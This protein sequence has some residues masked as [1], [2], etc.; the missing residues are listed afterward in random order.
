MLLT[1]CC[2]TRHELQQQTRQSGA[3]GVAVSFMGLTLY[4]TTIAVVGPEEM[5]VSKTGI[6]C[7]QKDISVDMPVDIIITSRD[8]WGA[9]HPCGPESDW[10]ISAEE[11]SARMLSME[12]VACCTITAQFLPLKPGRLTIELLYK[13]SII[14]KLFINIKP[15]Q[16]YDPKYTKL[17]L[18]NDTGQDIT[19]HT[20]LMGKAKAI[21]TVSPLDVTLLVIST[22]SVNGMAAAGPSSDDIVI[23]GAVVGEVTE[24]T[25]GLYKC[26]LSDFQYGTTDIEVDI[27]GITLLCP[28]TVITPGTNADPTRTTVRCNPPAVLRGDT[29]SVIISFYDA[30]GK[31]APAPDT[32]QLVLEPIG[33]I[34]SLTRVGSISRSTLEVVFVCEGLGLVGLVVNHSGCSYECTA[35]VCDI[36]NM[37]SGPL[38]L[39]S[40][41]VSLAPDPV[42]PGN[43]VQC[44]ITVRDFRYAPLHDVD[45]PLNIVLRPLENTARV[46]TRVQAVP[47]TAS[48]W[49]ATFTAGREAGETGVAVEVNGHVFY[50]TAM[51]EEELFD[52]LD[53]ELQRLREL[54]N[55]LHDDTERDR[56]R[57]GSVAR[58][59]R[60]YE[61][62]ERVAEEQ[63][64]E[65]ELT[66]KRYFS[67]NQQK[68]EARNVFPHFGLEVTDSIKFRGGLGARF[69]YAGVKVVAVKGASLSS[70]VQADD[71]ITK[72]EGKQ[73]EFLSDFRELVQDVQPGQSVEL[74]VRS[75][76][77][78]V[79]RNITIVPER[80]SVPSAQRLGYTRRIR[81]NPVDVGLPVSPPRL[82]RVARDDSTIRSNS[83][84]RSRR[85]VLIATYVTN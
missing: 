70:G 39:D 85:F 40:T 62:P 21:Q 16:I 45:Q 69:E 27:D 1:T 41:D 25:T 60:S 77:D 26:L 4:A 9:P 14:S 2:V 30:A 58:S 38:F 48:T 80:S 63:L 79:E 78:D 12:N 81:V 51:V 76:Y 59:H 67:Q 57:I 10:S 75:K 84:S 54:T 7:N 66:R 35:C 72:V 61:Q 11:D 46:S 55:R 13:K 71:I 64:Q 52:A 83:R 49:V 36:H 43:Q 82:P 32:S 24:V 20:K 56:L 73:V 18:R 74:V 68:R 22:Y 47:G 31:P 19:Q 50:A 8:R 3:A 53:D 28:I 34:S 44:L 29:I 5:D 17:V 37:E 23:R 15:R 65:L 33:E 42:R 6:S